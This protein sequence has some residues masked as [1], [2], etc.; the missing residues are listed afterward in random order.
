MY[1]TIVK[2]FAGLLAVYAV[3]IVGIFVIQF[4]WPVPSYQRKNPGATRSIAAM[5]S[6]HLLQ[7]AGVKEDEVAPP[8]K[9]ATP[10]PFA[11]SAFTAADTHLSP[12]IIS[13]S[14][15]ESYTAVLSK[16]ESALTASFNSAL[17]SGE[18]ITEEEAV[19]FVAANAWGGKLDEAI[20]RVPPQIKRASYRTYLSAPYFGSLSSTYRSL[21][22]ELVYCR[23][24]LAAVKGDTSR[25]FAALETKLMTDYIILNPASRDVLSVL[26]TVAAAPSLSVDTASLLLLTYSKLHSNSISYSSAAIL[27]DILPKCFD[28]IES[29][30]TADNDTLTITDTENAMSAI[31][32]G[33]A[34]I[35]AGEAAKNEGAESAGRAIVSAYYATKDFTLSELSVLEEL[36]VRPP[37]YPH[38]E[39]LSEGIY[40]FTC[41]NSVSYKESKDEIIMETMT[42][43]IATHYMIA[44]PIKSFSDIYIYGIPFHTDQRFET[45]NSSGFV[46]V[47]ATSTLLLKN[48][49]K[50]TKETIRLVYKGSD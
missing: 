47:P 25:A 30:I 33:A 20:A 45:Y 32:A 7:G 19:A 43:G 24:T 41:A 29:R 4:K 26:Q 35:K 44:A 18:E 11:F 36:L 15:K 2:K 9:E 39:V 38:L 10:P 48:R 37:H 1:T 27:K 28:T 8:A 21:E 17:S 6:A 16:I 50:D 12:A 49:Q 13:A 22:A 23:N 46:Y 42:E 3:V 40:A 31:R 14:K 34:L 5:A